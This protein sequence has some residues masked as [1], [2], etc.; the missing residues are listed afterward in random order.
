M[1]NLR[2][3]VDVPFVVVGGVAARLY[4]PERQTDDIDILVADRDAARLQGQL[5]AAGAVKQRDLTIGGSAWRLPDGTVLDVLT[6][7]EAWAG[8]A[9]G[10][11]VPGPDG[12]PIVSLP[13]LVL[14]KMISSRAID[15]ADVSRLLGAADE[16]SLQSVRAVIGRFLPDASEDVESLAVLGRLELEG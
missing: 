7:G 6:S 4:A 5:L 14:L 12:L 1:F 10:S 3:I 9:V 15:V 2:A 8:E 11:A 13:F 16:H